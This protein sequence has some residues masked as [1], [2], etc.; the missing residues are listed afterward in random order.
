MEEKK[1]YHALYRQKKDE[2]HTPEEIL[3]AFDSNFCACFSLAE[4]RSH[5]AKTRLFGRIW[6]INPEALIVQVDLFVARPEPMAARDQYLVISK[7]GT[8]ESNALLAQCIEESG[9]VTAAWYIRSQKRG[10]IKICYRHVFDSD[11]PAVVHKVNLLIDGD[12][13]L[14]SVRNL[15]H[16]DHTR[17]KE[18]ES[19]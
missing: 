11:K 9:A 2:T 5:S 17:M 12:G 6:E 18:E 1:S 19:T 7:N 13:L 4:D 10:D 14:L 8:K 15:S 16:A 3:Q